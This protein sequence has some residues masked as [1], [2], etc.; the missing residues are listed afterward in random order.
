MFQN[1][2][3]TSQ[4]GLLVETMKG[5][6]SSNEGIGNKQEKDKDQTMDQ[7]IEWF[8]SSFREK[9]G[10]KLSYYDQRVIANRNRSDCRDNR[11]IPLALHVNE[12]YERTVA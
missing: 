4:G 8:S 12:I 3:A 5:W 2:Q 9:T 11:Y 10:N 6:E 7:V 1:N